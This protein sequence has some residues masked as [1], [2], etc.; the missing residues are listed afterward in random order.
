MHIVCPQT[1]GNIRHLGEVLPFEIRFNASRIRFQLMCRIS[2]PGMVRTPG[3]RLGSA[4][5]AQRS[6]GRYLEPLYHRKPFLWKTHAIST[7]A[8]FFLQ[9]VHWK[10]T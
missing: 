7:Q 2:S 9:L 4:Q 1:V 5:C 6:T 3:H 10:V 8:H